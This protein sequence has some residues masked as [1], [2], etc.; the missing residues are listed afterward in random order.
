MIKT[1]NKF[2][3]N[4]RTAG[5]GGI[6]MAVCI[7]I[8]LMGTT[9]QTRADTFRIAMVSHAPDG[10]P[11]WNVVK[12]GIKDADADFG[13]S[14]DYLNAPQGGTGAMKPLLE[15]LAGYDAVIS[16]LADFSMTGPALQGISGRRVPLI[17][18]NNGTEEE[19]KA[20]GAFTHIGLDDYRAGMQVGR[21]AKAAGVRSLLCISHLD[22]S[23]S[24]LAR[25]NGFAEMLGNSG[26]WDLVKVGKDPVAAQN[27]IAR[28]LSSPPYPDA[29]LALGPLSAEP[30]IRAIETSGATNKKIFF[31][32]FDYS[33]KVIDAIRKG[34][35]QVAVDQQPYL[36]GYLPVAILAIMLRQDT[37]AVFNIRKT[38]YENASFRQRIEKY[39]LVPS[40]TLQKISTEAPLIT[41]KN[42]D[43][44]APYAG[45]YR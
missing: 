7:A 44:V 43:A 29:I 32:T 23:S 45:T 6:A 34:V 30:A 19:S 8:A 39:N 38:L 18:I 37:R 12:N 1:G 42:V 22:S 36:Q 31:V 40:Y 16:T 20:V 33:P 35:V 13:V 11:W 5:V 9:T 25:C 3:A 10:D 26:N 4:L 41:I 14:T 21:L 28:K 17:T 24:A 15:K 2:P 27:E